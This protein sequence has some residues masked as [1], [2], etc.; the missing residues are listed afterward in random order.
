MDRYQHIEAYLEYLARQHGLSIAVKD[1]AGFAAKDPDVGLSLTGHCIHQAAYC[2]F[3]KSRGLWDRCQLQSRALERRCRAGGC[4][5][6]LCY[7]GFSEL[8]LPVRY[9]GRLIAAVCA[10]GF[11]LDAAESRRRRERLARAYRIDPE[12]LEAHYRSSMTASAPDL[13]T[14]AAA[15]GL[16]ADFCRMYYQALAA[17]GVIDPNAALVGD[18]PRLNLLTNVIEYVH[19]NFNQDIRLRDIAA[20]CG[21]SESYVSHL[22]NQ[23][24]HVNLSQFV[25]Q[26]RIAR[27]RRT[28]AEGGSVLRAALDA[29]FSDP[30]YFSSVFRRLTGE[31]PSGYARSL[32]AQGGK[33][34]AP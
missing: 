16:L 31:T 26:V 20:F 18:S 12:K 14:Y 1:Y 27:A 19:L 3:L 29:G 32:W 6:G 7:A 9:E 4:F 25:N 11:E 28:L 24:M 21:C 10:G 2:L 15:A 34:I 22:F 5:A 13:A 23:H 8:V 17:A 30:N 33:G